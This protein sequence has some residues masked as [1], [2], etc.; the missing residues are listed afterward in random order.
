MSKT[1]D[2][3]EGLRNSRHPRSRRF[4]CLAAL[5]ATYPFR[6]ALGYTCPGWTTDAVLEAPGSILWAGSKVLT[7]PQFEQFSLHEI[8]SQ[9]KVCRTAVNAQVLKVSVF[10]SGDDRDQTLNPQKIPGLG[11]GGWL[12]QYT[13]YQPQPMATVLIIGDQVIGRRLTANGMVE[14][15]PDGPLGTLLD[16][17]FRPHQKHTGGD[18]MGRAFFFERTHKVITQDL[19]KQLT[20]HITSKFSFPN[21]SVLIRNDSWFIDDLPFPVAYRFDTTS[22]EGRPLKP[23]A[24]KNYPQGS[25]ATCNRDLI[26]DLITANVANGPR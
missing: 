3:S 11:F 5:L 19:A 25:E 16:I 22:H 13:N 4:F 2:M 12:A 26:C 21:V 9:A 17:V 18:P 15:P 24:P 6:A 23:Q 14:A 1:R 8:I 20:S 10:T 7:Q